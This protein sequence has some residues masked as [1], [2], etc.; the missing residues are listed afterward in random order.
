MFVMDQNESPEII[1]KDT[2]GNIT[3][4][5]TLVENNKPGFHNFIGKYLLQY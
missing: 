4:T 5:L 1:F 2:S 3:N